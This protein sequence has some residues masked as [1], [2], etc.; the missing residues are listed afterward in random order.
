MADGQQQESEDGVQVVFDLPEGW[1]PPIEFATRLLQLI[2][3]VRA[4]TRGEDDAA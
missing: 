1:R 4:R 2:L 3:A